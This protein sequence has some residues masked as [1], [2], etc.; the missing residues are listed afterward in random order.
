MAGHKG[1]RRELLFL[2]LFSVDL[3]SIL[4]LSSS[5]VAKHWF[6]LEGL[7]LWLHW[8]HDHNQKRWTRAA[9]ETFW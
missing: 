2:F 6:P 8:K 9:S 7:P 5:T 1:V 3:I 4:T